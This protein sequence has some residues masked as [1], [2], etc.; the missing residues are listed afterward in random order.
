MN[1][2]IFIVSLLVMAFAFAPTIVAPPAHAEP[3]TA[4]IVCA[5]VFASAVITNEIIKS[6]PES[7]MALAPDEAISMN[8]IGYDLVNL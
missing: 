3:I 1:A 4:T 6:E 2:N 7:E 8:Q 5:T